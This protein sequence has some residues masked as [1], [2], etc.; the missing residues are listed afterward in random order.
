MKPLEDKIAVVTGASRGIGRAIA[1]RLAADGALVAVHYGKNA[2]FAEEVVA[3]IVTAGGKAFAV[4]A[5]LA[6]NAGPELLIAA[7][8]SE[9]NKRTGN[10]KFDILVNNA[11]VAEYVDLAQTE[12]AQFDRV[13]QVNV[14]S[15]FFITKL[16]VDR[17]R[18]GGRI[19]NISSIVSRT[20]FPGI[21]AYAMTKGAVDV[22]TL[23]MAGV[24]GARGITV[25]AVAPGATETDMSPW[26]KEDHGVAMIKQMQALPRVGKPEDVAA[27]VAFAASSDA[28]W[29]TGQVLDA[30]GGAKL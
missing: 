11:G 7:L 28:G 13:F 12:Q 2:A 27:V 10:S 8:D 14:K 17:I 18:D 6:D 25:N 24:L 19:I 3:E 29:V 4:Q 30:S 22:F 5:D 23:Q 9:L 26:L 20:S 15:L 21:T 16:A 1:T